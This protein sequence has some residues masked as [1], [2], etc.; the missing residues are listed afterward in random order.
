[1]T[2]AISLTLVLS[3]NTRSLSHTLSLEFMKP[4]LDFIPISY[5]FPFYILPFFISFFIFISVLLEIH[6][7]IP[8]LKKTNPPT[9]TRLGSDAR[10]LYPRRF[11][12][13]QTR[14][15]GSREL[16][17][18]IAAVQSCVRGD[19]RTRDRDQEGL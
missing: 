2:H 6:G 10:Q 19:G 12:P 8:H 14:S 17:Q 18:R 1:M 15:S 4:D 13:R 5:P 3:H 11:F 9:A 7:S 16:H